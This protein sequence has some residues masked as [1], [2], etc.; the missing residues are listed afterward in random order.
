MT[1]LTG[2]SE[3]TIALAPALI[4]LSYPQLHPEPAWRVYTTAGLPE[5]PAGQQGAFR[6]PAE[7]AAGAAAAGERGT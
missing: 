1:E 5:T 3:L 6:G 2:N 4:T 7:A